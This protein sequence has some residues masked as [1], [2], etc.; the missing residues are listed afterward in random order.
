MDLCRLSLV[1]WRPV[2]YQRKD[3]F[4]RRAKSEGYRSR[5]A[6]KLLEL[7]RRHRI[8]R[9]GDRVV[10]LGAWPGGWLQVAAECVGEGGRVAG[11]DL[12]PIDPLPQPWVILFCADLEDEN[13]RAAVATAIGGTADV[14][15]SDMAPKLSGIR[16][17]DEAAASDLARLALAFSQQALRRGGTLVLKLFDGPG[18]RDL[19]SQIH[20]SFAS[21]NAV[22]PEAT[23]KGSSELYVLCGG[24]R[25][26]R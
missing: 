25:P 21:V 14:V 7:H 23:R 24:Y 9:R 5:A 8:F 15:L 19:I 22:R 12:V 18:T 16:D 2:A 4:Y 11:I 26:Q 10:D 6:Y 1:A 17:R 13:V 3:A 20:K